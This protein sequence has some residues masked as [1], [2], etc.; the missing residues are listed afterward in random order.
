MDR[1]VI[2]SGKALGAEVLGVDLS[3]PLN[4]DDTA[5]IQNAWRDHL[6]LL[7]RDQDLTPDNLLNIVTA[8]GGIQETGSRKNFESAGHKAGSAR[9]SA[10]S[11]VS[12]I[13]NLDEDGKPFLVRPHASGSQELF[14]HTDNSYVETPPNGSFLHSLQV[15]VDGG[16]D[17]SFVN[18]YTAY[19]TLPEATKERIVGLHI[20]HDN[21]KNTSGGA[22]PT[23]AQPTGR[24][25]VEGP[26]HP[27]VRIHPDT[28]RKALYLGRRYKWPS[29]FIVELEDDESETL[30]D[31]LWA[32]ATQ[33]SLKWTHSWKPKEALLWDNRCTMHHRTQ[34]DPTQ[35]RVLQRALIK[36]GPIIA[37]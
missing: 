36:G 26:V 15:P 24:D 16:G 1:T 31:E 33:D 28:N 2:P 9:V 29:S 6:V 20:K 12:Y 14:W 23:V 22:R 8:L 13:S 21:S 37:A 10:V 18:Q 3:A 32:H 5:F 19:E 17:T 35:A 7:F 25:E 30:L 27:I 4:D 34:A 11:G